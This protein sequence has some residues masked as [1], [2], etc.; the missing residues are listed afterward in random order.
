MESLWVHQELSLL[1]AARQLHS[2]LVFSCVRWRKGP[3]FRAWSCGW[4][5]VGSQECQPRVSS[6]HPAGLSGDEVRCASAPV[7]LTPGHRPLRQSQRRLLCFG[8]LSWRA[9]SQSTL[10]FT[11][12]LPAGCPA[13][14]PA[15]CELTPSLRCD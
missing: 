5:E 13:P 15:V 2:T 9:P 3:R 10:I 14:L 6:P 7:L 12:C 11:V 1:C 8:G 4:S